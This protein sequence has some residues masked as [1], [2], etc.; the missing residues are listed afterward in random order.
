VSLAPTTQNVD[1]E[2]N[3]PSVVDLGNSAYLLAAHAGIPRVWTRHSGMA[4][5]IAIN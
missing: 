4:T 5:A 1:I 3:S 2:T